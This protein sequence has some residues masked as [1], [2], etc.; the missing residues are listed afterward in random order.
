MSH[1]TREKGMIHLLFIHVRNSK[2]QFGCK[3]VN[4]EQTDKDA[5]TLHTRQALTISD[6]HRVYQDFQAV[7]F[8]DQELNLPE[9]NG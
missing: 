9:F 5:P 3:V 2:P 4:D 6:I 7:S 8:G 1:L